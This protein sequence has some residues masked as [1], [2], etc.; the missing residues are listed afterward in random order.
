LNK[1]ETVNTVDMAIVAKAFGS[2]PGV[3]GWNAV[4]DMDVNEVINIVDVAKVAESY[5]KQTNP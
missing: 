5:G 2:R 4:A 1:D 3:P